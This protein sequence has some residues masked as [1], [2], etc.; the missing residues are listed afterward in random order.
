MRLTIYDI[1]AYLF[2]ALLPNFLPPLLK[3]LSL[4]DSTSPQPTQFNQRSWQKDL[5]SDVKVTFDRNP[6]SV[7][8]NYHQR[9]VI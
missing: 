2:N 4:H 7:I 3:Q 8:M 9:H 5:L 1:S 6:V